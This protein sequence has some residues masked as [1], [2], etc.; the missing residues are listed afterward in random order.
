MNDLP[1]RPHAWIRDE[2]PVPRVTVNFHTSSQK[3]GLP[4]YEMVVENNP[5]WIMINETLGKAKQLRDACENEL[6]PQPT[7]KALEDSLAAELW[8]ELLAL[9]WDIDSVAVLK[10]V[11]KWDAATAAPLAEGA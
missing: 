11:D 5:S 9:E 3:G 8:R 10:L 2:Q 7:A 6:A 4:A 1:E